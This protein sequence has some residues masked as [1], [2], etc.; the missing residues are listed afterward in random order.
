MERLVVFQRTA[1]WMIPNR[2]YH[3]P[4][5]PGAQWAMRHL[6]GYA[7]WYRFLLLWQATDKMLDIARVDPDWPG[8]PQS[9]N[10]R[11]ARFRESILSWIDEHVG[12]DPELVGEGRARLPTARQA[13][14][15][16]QRELAALPRP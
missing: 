1:Q 10:A 9:A 16:G 4:V 15:P 3:E 14:A 8:L 6:P 2:L 13:A 12:D 5:D 7:R 11:S